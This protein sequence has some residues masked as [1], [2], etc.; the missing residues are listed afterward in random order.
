MQCSAVLAELLLTFRASLQP[1]KE[2]HCPTDGCTGLLTSAV[3]MVMEDGLMHK[4]EV[5]NSG[6]PR[7]AV[8]TPLQAPALPHK[9]TGKPA[10]AQ[11]HCL[12]LL[13]LSMP[14]VHRSSRSAMAE[15]LHAGRIS[16]A[17]LC[18]DGVPY[19]SAWTHSIS[20]VL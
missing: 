17:P 7:K 4:R 14:A 15:A 5:F 20:F 16:L 8:N 3:H 13:A 18:Y 1:G 11:E 9:S 2:A 19:L 10:S 6:R 12:L